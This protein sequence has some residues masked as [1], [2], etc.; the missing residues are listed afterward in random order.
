MTEM[1]TAIDKMHGL[2]K[3]LRYQIDKLLS[4]TTSASAFATA[5]GE[6]N[7]SNG[8]EDPLIFRPNRK[9]LE[10]DDS[11]SSINNDGDDDDDDEAGSVQDMDEQGTNHD[12]DEESVDA[13]ADDD[14]DDQSD[15]DIAAARANISME[16]TGSNPRN[17][18]AGQQN[19]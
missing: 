14:D 7:E 17:D 6:G 2:N 13:D 5:D 1:K 4:S 18:D 10:N 15:G 12:E 11:D 19:K 16:S 3:K 8:P 9:S